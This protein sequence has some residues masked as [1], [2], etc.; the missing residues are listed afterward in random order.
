MGFGGMRAKNNTL[1]L[2]PFLPNNWESYS[3]RIDF[4]G[5]HLSLKKEKNK[6]TLVNYSKVDVTLLVWGKPI[7][8]VGNSTKEII[9]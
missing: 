7:Q 1:I 3:F 9:K 6:L 5:A 4:R 2:N 8:L